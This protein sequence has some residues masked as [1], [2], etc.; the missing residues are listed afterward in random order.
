MALRVPAMVASGG[1]S[2][3][4]GGPLDVS[5]LNPGIKPTTGAAPKLRSNVFA[6]ASRRVRKL[7]A[8]SPKSLLTVAEIEE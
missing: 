4:S 6:A 5:A 1:A 3:V 7:L 2:A 8:P